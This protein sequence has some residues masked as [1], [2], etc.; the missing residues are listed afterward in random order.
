MLPY[1]MPV[2]RKVDNMGS[3][4]E[5]IVVSWIIVTLA[6]RDLWRHLQ[7]G[8]FFHIYYQLK[9]LDVSEPTILSGP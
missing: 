8:N 5:T 6:V 1:L 9:V 7:E 2:Q 3:A 4:S